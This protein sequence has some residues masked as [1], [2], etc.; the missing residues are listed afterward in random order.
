MSFLY[1]VCSDA[2]CD[3]SKK[4]TPRAAPNVRW[5]I[6]TPDPQLIRLMR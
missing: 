6:R 3:A 1:P 2:N 4:N 5:E